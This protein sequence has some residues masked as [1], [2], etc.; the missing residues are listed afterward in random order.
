MILSQSCKLWSSASSSVISND[1][2]IYLTELLCRVYKTVLLKLAYA[3]SRHSVNIQW[4]KFLHLNFHLKIEKKKSLKIWSKE[5]YWALHHMGK[6]QL[7]ARPPS[8]FYKA[9]GF[10]LLWV[11]LGGWL[12][13]KLYL[14]L[15]ETW[16]VC[17]EKNPL[18][19]RPLWPF[20]G[21]FTY[22]RGR[23]EV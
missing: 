5:R 8:S 22:S 3:G 21:K 1:N 10:Q 20:T 17:L 23:E 15:P 11:F 9:Q 16:G 18:A 6:L 12:L 2:G 7:G 13:R 4:I 14:S 19:K